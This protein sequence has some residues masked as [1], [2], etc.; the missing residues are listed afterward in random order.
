MSSAPVAY[1]A[2]VIV[3]RDARP[4]LFVIALFAVLI[5]RFTKVLVS[6]KLE[7]GQAITVIPG[8]FRITH[9]LNFGAAFSM[10][11][12]SA[13]P[14]A[15]RA[16]LIVFSV[17]AGV[18]V[19]TMLWK[20]GRVFSPAS[21]GLALIFGG[22]IGNLYDRIRLHYVIDFLEVHIVHYHWPD[23]NV[24]DSCISVGA[25]LLLLELLWPKPKQTHVEDV[26]VVDGAAQ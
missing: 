26:S 2:E 5:D 10:F 6:S 22:A 23:F 11:A 17:V 13:S 7:T 16:S 4:W 24:A 19:F 1:D 12:E 25:V 15:V 8:V 14:V 21:V 20:M 9:V 3:R 18:I